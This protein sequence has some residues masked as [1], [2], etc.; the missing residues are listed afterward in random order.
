MRQGQG[1]LVDRFARERG[2]HHRQ[3]DRKRRREHHEQHPTAPATRACAPCAARY[4]AR[5]DD[6]CGAQPLHQPRAGSLLSHLFNLQQHLRE[7]H[8]QLNLTFVVHNDVRG[9][10]RLLPLGELTRQARVQGPV[11]SGRGPSCPDLLRRRRS[12]SSRRTPGPGP[13]RTAA[14]PRRWPPAEEAPGR[15]P[16]RATRLSRRPRAATGAARAR[17]DHRTWRMRA[18]RWPRGPRDR[19]ARPLS[20]PPHDL[21]ADLGSSYS[22]ARPRPSRARRRRAVAAPPGRS[23]YRP[24]S[25]P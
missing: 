2:Q 8:R 3:A 21:V 4:G 12:R 11:V 19:A 20:E 24:R 14:A 1:E 10:L 22:R 15:T 18:Q 25:R 23:T 7:L 17:R 13:T 5:C 16:A 6:R 9:P